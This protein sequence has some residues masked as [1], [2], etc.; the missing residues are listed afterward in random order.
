ML[1]GGITKIRVCCDAYLIQAV[2]FV[3][4]NSL[5]NIFYYGDAVSIPAHRC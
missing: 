2:L 5:S 3:V 4:V 1:L